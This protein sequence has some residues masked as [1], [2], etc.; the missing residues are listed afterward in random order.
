VRRAPA[1]RR[2]YGWLLS[3]FS[4]VIRLRRDERRAVGRTLSDLIIIHRHLISLTAMSE[5]LRAHA[6][7][8]EQEHLQ[9]QIIMEAFYPVLGGLRQRYDE[10]VKVVT[11]I[12]PLIGYELAQQSQLPPALTKRRAFAASNEQTAIS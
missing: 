2:R 8:N 5:T 11:G 3:E 9:L 6:S 4:Q 7:F 10:S 1:H 12:K